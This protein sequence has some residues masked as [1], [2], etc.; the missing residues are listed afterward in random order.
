M[1]SE[2]KRMFVCNRMK[3]KARRVLPPGEVW[4]E[5]L[6]AT[7]AAGQMRN[8]AFIIKALE[9]SK[10]HFNASWL[11]THHLLQRSPGSLGLGCEFT[12]RH[13]FM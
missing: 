13:S 9:F 5:C 10:I 2:N 11:L 6:D 4:R 7:N 3:T 12:G 1:D 8:N